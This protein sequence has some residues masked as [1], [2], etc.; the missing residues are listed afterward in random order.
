MY[1]KHIVVFGLDNFGMSTIKQ[2]SKYKCETL[3]I[4]KRIDRVEIAA[5]YA[6]YSMQINVQDADDFDELSLNSYDIAIITFSN[7]QSS[8]LAALVCKENNIPVVIAKAN[9]E[10]HKKIL[11]KMD[12]DKIILPE[13]EMGI[14][15]AKGIM[16]KSIIEIVDLSEDYSIVELN[17]QNK[18]D[19]KTLSELRLR[20]IYGFNVLCIKRKAD[21]I[22]ISPLPEQ[23]VKTGDILVGIA[24][25]EKFNKKHRNDDENSDEVEK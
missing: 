10:T 24:L 8:I 14:K 12:V 23:V 6:T 15:L 3:A 11:K 4:D 2:L 1:K 17:V 16:N 9:D 19:N 18:W 5:E 20:N 25:N 22:I 21:N 13:E 7:I